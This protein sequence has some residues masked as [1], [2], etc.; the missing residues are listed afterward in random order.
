MSKKVNIIGAGIAGLCAGSYLR[1]NGYETEIFEMHNLPGGLCTSWERKGFRF[2][3]CIHWL[4]GSSPSDDFFLL[5]NELIDMKKLTFIDH[6]EYM[7]IEGE[8]GQFIS[9]STNID[10]FEKELLTKAPEDKELIDTF[11]SAARKLMNMKLPVDKVA[12]VASGWDKMKMLFKLMPYLGAMKKWSSISAKD[13]AAKCKN[14][15]LQKTIIHMFAPEMSVLFLLMIMV[16]MHKKCA[17][18]PIGGSLNFARLIEKRYIELGGKIHYNSRVKKILTTNNSASGVLL[19]N[20]ETCGCDIVVS[21]AD[22]HASIFEMLDGRY[23]DETIKGYYDNY[24]I[25]PSLVQVS[26]GVSRT[27]PGISHSVVFPLETPLQ[28]DPET[29]LKDI[30]FHIY[31]YDPTLAPEGKTIITSLLPTYNYTYWTELREKDREKYKAEKE[32]VGDAVVNI[33][34]EKLGNIRANLDILDVSTP[35]T[36]IRFTGNWKGSFEG[37]QLTPEVSLKQMKKVLPGLENFYMAGQW[38]EPGGGLPACII[39]GRGAAQVICKKDKKKFTSMH[40]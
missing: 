31:N 24:R 22:G 32:R 1:M 39:S 40:Y 19:E 12:E 30:S 34:E 36:L 26:A 7:R 15:L 14:P 6:T 20:G 17:G 27:F 9:I 28:I 33:M 2:D 25:F 11:I 18:Y 29:Q 3:G 21:A 38:V 16:W 5:W 37:W 35:A 4:V 8:N 13:F 23:T 10:E